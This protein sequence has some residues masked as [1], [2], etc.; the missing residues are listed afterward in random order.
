M[1]TFVM[2]NQLKVSSNLVLLLTPIITTLS[3]DILPSSAA[4]LNRP[5]SSLSDTSFT[6]FNLSSPAQLIVSDVDANLIVSNSSESLSDQQ[7]FGQ[8]EDERIDISDQAGSVFAEADFS[9]VALDSFFSNST[10]NNAICLQPTCFGLSETDSSILGEFLVTASPDSPA[11]FGFSW[12]LES[13]LEASE[14]TNPSQVS[15]AIGDA[16]LQVCFENSQGQSCDS[17]ISTEQILS[18]DGETNI[19]TVFDTTGEAF[20]VDLFRFQ[21]F[22]P[23]SNLWFVETL[24]LGTYQQT[25]TESTKVVILQSQNTQAV[26]KAPEPSSTIALLSLSAIGTALVAKKK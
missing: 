5:L 22:D 13:L 19:S 15:T 23:D 9:N 24:A 16:S 10:T 6:L 2:G 26:V 12:N 7:S 20:T 1:K 21:E 17:L 11:S 8:V 25:F 14:T 18:L 4:T 3:W